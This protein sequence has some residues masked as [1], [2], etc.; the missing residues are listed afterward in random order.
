MVGTLTDEILTCQDTV[1]QEKYSGLTVW[2][3]VHQLELQLC[4]S[5]SMGQIFGLLIIEGKQYVYFTNSF[6]L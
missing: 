6:D 2:S 1:I 5:Q 4:I 3:E